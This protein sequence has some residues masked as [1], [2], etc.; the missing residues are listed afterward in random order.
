MPIENESIAVLRKVVSV[1]VDPETAFEIFTARIAEWWPLETHSVGEEE[2]VSVVFGKRVGET[3]DET[4]ADGSTQT[5][6]EITVWE[7]PR[8]VAFTWHPGNPLEQAGLVEVT[9]TPRSSTSTVVALEHSGWERRPDGV[10]ARQN[11]DSGWD[12]VLERFTAGFTS[13]M[14]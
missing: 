1:P 6:G 4:L 7:P 5:W 13:V 3:I 8:R 12:R 11:Y 2:A 10:R 14:H 9:F